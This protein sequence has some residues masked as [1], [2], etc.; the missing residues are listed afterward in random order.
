MKTSS[1]LTVSSG[2]DGEQS[3][4]ERV[5]EAPVVGRVVLLG[6]VHQRGEGQ[7]GHPDQQ[8]EQAEL[9]GGLPDGE[10][11]RL[12]AGKV[13]DQLED[14]QDLGDPD[15][16]DDLAGLADDVELGEVVHDEVDE[17]GEDGEEVDEVHGLDEELDLLRRARQPDEVLDGEVDRGE[18][19]HPQDDGGHDVALVGGG[20]GVG[21]LGR[22]GRLRAR[23]HNVELGVRAAS[24]GD[25]DS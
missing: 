12:Q 16:P 13:P 19:V 21:L 1:Q 24:T 25:G 10:E 5:H 8:D 20:L 15:Q 6:E 11:E 14:P 4:P 2:G 22:G 17:V 9:A 23:V 3:P 18:G 7:D